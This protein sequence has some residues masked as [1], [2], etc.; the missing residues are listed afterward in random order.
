MCCVKLESEREGNVL[1]CFGE[2][3]L[4]VLAPFQFWGGFLKT[5]GV[6]L[7]RKAGVKRNTEIAGIRCIWNNIRGSP[8]TEAREADPVGTCSPGQSLGDAHSS[9]Q[10]RPQSQEQKHGTHPGKQR[11]TESGAL[12]RAQDARV[13]IPAP[14]CSSYEPMS[15]AFLGLLFENEIGPDFL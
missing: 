10:Q 11:A 12:R 4:R 9:H 1:F 13:L 15:T 14:P 2:G 8:R 7:G 6:G 3:Y 5:V